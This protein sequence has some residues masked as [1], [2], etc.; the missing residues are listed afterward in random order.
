MN[1]K[2]IENFTV[3]FRHRL[4]FASV[5]QHSQLWDWCH[6]EQF[7]VGLCVVNCLVFQ[8]T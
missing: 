2:Y 3:C 7:Y 5:G 4:S 6:Q 8:W 1:T